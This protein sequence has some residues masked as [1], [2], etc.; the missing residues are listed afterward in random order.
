MI[1]GQMDKSKQERKQYFYTYSGELQGE[2][3]YNGKNYILN[4]GFVSY[5]F[6][7][8]NCRNHLSKFTESDKIIKRAKTNQFTIL[9]SDGQRIECQ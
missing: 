4:T 7:S 3:T 6:S 8:D 2:M 9:K 1:K 5:E